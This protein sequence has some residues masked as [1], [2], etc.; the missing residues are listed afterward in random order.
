MAG[1][2]DSDAGSRQPRAGVGIAV[3]PRQVDRAAGILLG[4]ACGDALGVPYEFTQRVGADEVPV[5]AGGGLGPY[6]PGEYS[7]DT[8]M[9]ACIAQVAAAG[10]DLRTEEA[11]DAIASGFLDWAAG[12]ASDIGAQTRAVLAAARQDHGA[13]PAQALRAAARA[14]HKRTRRTAG[15][16]S[17]MRAGVVAL[18]Y[19]GDVDALADAARGRQRPDPS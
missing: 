17:L 5:M 1:N 6:A 2:Q 19:L 3:S 8:Q 15:N 4:A 7:D 18:P 9:A 13:R 12:G 10:A 14:L 16:G 11:L